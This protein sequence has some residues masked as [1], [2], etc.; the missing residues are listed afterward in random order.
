MAATGAG[1]QQWEPV[2]VRYLRFQYG[3][4]D[5]KQ[6]NIYLGIDLRRTKITKIYTFSYIFFDK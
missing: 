6:A 4:I 3:M 1:P 2:N 5:E